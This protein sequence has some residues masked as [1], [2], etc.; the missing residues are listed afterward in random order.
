MNNG[1]SS[2][3]HATNTGT[4]ATTY[5]GGGLNLPVSVAIDGAGQ[6]W[7]A[8]TSNTLSVFANDGSNV[9]P[10]SGYQ[11]ATAHQASALNLPS[12]IAI[13]GSGSV[14]IT[15]KAN[16]TVTKVFGAAVPV[17]APTS[18]AVTNNT[19]GTKP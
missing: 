5:T 10:G 7:I 19:V 12:S 16:G 3:L 14:W 17:V 13:D 1:S 2:L 11:A 18:T 15:D 9:S 6:V 4:G 8:N